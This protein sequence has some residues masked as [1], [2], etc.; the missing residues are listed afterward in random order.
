MRKAWATS[1]TSIQEYSECDEDVNAELFI[2]LLLTIYI[3]F[4]YI[5][6]PIIEVKLGWEV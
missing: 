6:L 4:I 1:V 5:Y 3:L 2:Y